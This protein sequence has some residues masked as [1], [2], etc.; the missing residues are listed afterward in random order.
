MKRLWILAAAVFVAGLVVVSPRTTEVRAQARLMSLVSQENGHAALGLALRRL[1]VNGIF[2]ETA[3][4]PDDEHNQLYALLTLG[5]GIR[6]VDVQTTRGEG[7]QN[8]IGPELFRDIAVLRTSELLSAH[9]LD[10]AEQWFIRAIDY[11]Y[12]FDP[13]EIYRAWGRDDVVGDFVRM[14]RMHRPDVVL[15][16]SIQGRGGDRAHEATAV[17]TREAFRAAADPAR[18]PEQIR[19]GLRP[20][21]ARKLYFTGG[22]GVI[23]GPPP[24]TP[25]SE[26]AGHFATVDSGVYDQLLGR[27]YTDIGNDAR[28]YHKCQGMG[29]LPL[30]VGGIGGGRGPSGASRYRLVDSSIPGEMDKDEMSL[31]EG[32]DTSLA[33]LASFAGPNPPQGLTAG[34]AAIAE[35]ARLAQ[36][37]SDSGDDA[38]TAVPVV[39]GL[40]AV[41][42]LRAELGAMRLAETAR[43][44]IDFRLK[45]KEADYERAALLASGLAFEAV[46]DDGLVVAGQPVKL[47][48]AVANRGAV[49]VAVTG[50]GVSGF[51]QP[52]A[53]AAGTAKPRAVFTCTVDVRV[54]ADA[55]L[56]EPYWTDQVPGTLGRPR[57]RSTSSRQTSSSARRSGRRPSAPRSA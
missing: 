53:C 19:A 46:A 52:A 18:Y 35:Q 57:P 4:H 20:W 16:M 42:A 25:S 56:T 17:L 55:R 11:G 43:F 38:G 48:F 51:A 27:T 34:L 49:D 12:S 33:G 5:Q 3:A 1:N 54:P 24:S 14:I 32:V 13:A 15:T 29:L 7:G 28:S 31:F 37:T 6:S 26:P 39:A 30:L 23:G 44:E 2:L 45:I 47:S 41:R 9:R 21:Q 50:V 22:S 8:E 10:G 36:R 40:N